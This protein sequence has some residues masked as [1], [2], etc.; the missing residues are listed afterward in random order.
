V[1]ASECIAA[2][3]DAEGEPMKSKKSQ[4]S[5]SL[6]RVPHKLR[7]F[8]TENDLELVREAELFDRLDRA[9]EREK[10]LESGDYEFR[11][12]VRNQL[13]LDE[14]RN[15]QN[16]RPR[17]TLETMLCQQMAAV[18]TKAMG[19][20]G[21]EG[22]GAEQALDPA[23]RLMRVFAAQVEALRAWRSRG[24]QRVVVEHVHVYGGGQAVIGAVST[25]GEK[26]LEQ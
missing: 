2:D 11:R 13:F 6:V 9:K 24:Q 19:F 20:I 21:R 16:L 17:D 18:H 23:I 5:K 26:N 22:N 3:R 4:S 14:E 1:F 8:V 25:G 7:P 15:R 12:A 10:N